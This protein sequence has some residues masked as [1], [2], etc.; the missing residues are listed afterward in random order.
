MKIH[1]HEWAKQQRLEIE[2]YRLLACAADS[3]F[4]MI[5]WALVL[6]TLIFLADKTDASIL[7]MLVW[8]CT[9]A[10]L[11]YVFTHMGYDLDFE[12]WPKPWNMSQMLTTMAV[13]LIVGGGGALTV[14]FVA[15]HVAHE[16]AAAG[17]L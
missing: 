7:H 8:L 5:E 14:I 2:F 3:L 11:V 6:A 9:C 12:I 15:N 10:I 1:L 13:R 16:V 4:R 17:L